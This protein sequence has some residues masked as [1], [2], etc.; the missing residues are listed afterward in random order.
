MLY[1]IVFIILANMP[2]IHY[3]Q[4]EL[5]DMDLRRRRGNDKIRLSNRFEF[6]R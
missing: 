5:G 6:L 4:N 3:I 2:A 1:L